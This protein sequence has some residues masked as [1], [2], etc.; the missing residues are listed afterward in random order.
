MDNGSESR[1]TP[2]TSC[3]FI[4]EIG[5]G[6]DSTFANWIGLGLAYQLAY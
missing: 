2:E 3:G 6:T 1:F 5:H 4:V